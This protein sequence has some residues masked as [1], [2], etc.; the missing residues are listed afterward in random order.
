MRITETA[1]L[2]PFAAAM[3]LSCSSSRNATYSVER[4]RILIDSSYDASPDRAATAFMAPYK[5]HVDSLMNPIVGYA[6]SNMSGYQPE[7][8]LTNLLSDILVWGGQAFNEHPDFAV[9]NVG[10]IRASLSKGA[11]TIGDVL[12]MAPFENKICFLTLSGS[13]VLELFRQIT[14]QG[15][16]GVSH[17]VR[18]VMDKH[19]NLLSAT[20]N[21]EPVDKARDY[22]IA[23]LDYVAQG[24][25]KMD[26]FKAKTNVVSP[27]SEENN[28]RYI[29]MNYFRYF[30]KQGKTVDSKVEGRIKVENPK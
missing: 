19:G 18:L 3:L 13:K 14:A 11:V 1:L 27:Q 22:R 7:S 20:I 21:G 28:I 5:A 10:G 4:T 24:N 25:D 9:Y 29:I 15:G 17:S 6:A 8:P 30:M 16:Q 23:T 12:D 2:V 26:A